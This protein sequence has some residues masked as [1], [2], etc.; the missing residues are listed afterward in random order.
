MRQDFDASVS[1]ADALKR[2]PKVCTG[3]KHQH[4]LGP[5]R[6]KKKAVDPHAFARVKKLRARTAAYWRGETDECP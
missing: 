2:I 4:R 1:Q 5:G 6:V 3:R